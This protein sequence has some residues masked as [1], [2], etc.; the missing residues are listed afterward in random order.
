MRRRVAFEAADTR[1]KPSALLTEL[2][3]WPV[4][5]TCGHIEISGHRLHVSVRSADVHHLLVFKPDD[6]KK[7]RGPSKGGKVTYGKMDLEKL[8][9]AGI[10]FN[11]LKIERIYPNATR[12]EVRKRLLPG[13]DPKDTI[14]GG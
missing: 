8:G 9:A 10:R 13:L 7:H 1:A 5:A 11:G 4:P 3:S 12:W 14:T 2:D 6:P